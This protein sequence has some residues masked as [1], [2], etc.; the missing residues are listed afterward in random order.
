MRKPDTALLHALA[1]RF[2][3]IAVLGTG[4]D[5]CDVKIALG[6]ERI[7]FSENDTVF[8]SFDLENRYW[9]GFLSYDL[10]NATEQLSS[11]NPD[12]LGFPAWY[13]FSPQYLLTLEES[14]YRIECDEERRNSAEY[15]FIE[16]L[17]NA[18]KPEA[19]PAERKGFEPPIRAGV[20]RE[21]YLTHIGHLLEHLKQGDIYEI[22]YCQEFSASPLSIDPAAV[23]EKL[24]Q[25]TVAPFSVFLKT[26]SRYLLCGSPERFLRRQGT[27]V[28][29]QPIKGTLRRGKEEAED[30]L[31]REQLARDPKERSENVMI[32]D[33]VRND[34]SRIAEKNSV[35]V[36]ELFGVYSFPTVHQLISTVKAEVALSHSAF[37]ILKAA[38]PMG[39]MTGAPKVKAMELAEHYETFRRGLY[40]GTVGYISPSGDFD[41]NVVIRSILYNAAT[42]Y[43]SFPVGSAITIHSDPAREY[44]ECLLKAEAMR[45]ALIS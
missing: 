41:F 31:L 36:P 44:D 7:R 29:S 39:S 26:G 35:S 25:L 38:F 28:I 22:N 18:P 1:A 13:F 23:Y 19:K 33:L 3:P 37:D 43:V 11:E 15:T 45:K 9:F 2:D 8:P 5:G 30:A 17:L 10:K 6:A 42:K 32:V 16:T 14:E 12:Q 24:S 21:T 4:L 34:L 27:E 20:S 40:S